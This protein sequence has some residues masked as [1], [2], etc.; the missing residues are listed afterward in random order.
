MDT[1]EKAHSQGGTPK[2]VPDRKSAP[3]SPKRFSQGPLAEMPKEM[4]EE[5]LLTTQ[6]VAAMLGI[7]PNTVTR[8]RWKGSA[9]KDD[10]DHLK[11]CRLIGNQVRYR[12]GDVIEFLERRK[13]SH[14]GEERL[15]RDSLQG[16]VGW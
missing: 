4:L 15:I 9:L 1:S 2:K 14:T 5:A 8:W 6:E 10:E 12:L 11:Y 7:S 16:G 13:V 3:S